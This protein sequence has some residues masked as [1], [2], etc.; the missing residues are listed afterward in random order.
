MSVYRD[1]STSHDI[2]TDAAFRAWAQ[3][4]HD[5]LAAVGLIQTADTGQIN[6]AT[7]LTPATSTF[8]GYEIWRFNDSDQ[9]NNPIYF[10]IEY[11][12]G[13]LAS[14]ENW[15]INVGTGS[16]GAG[17]LTNA[18]GA[19]AGNVAQ[20]VTGTPEYHCC[21]VDGTLIMASIP[22]P[23]T[24]FAGGF[25][26][27]IERLRDE[28]GAVITS[29]ANRGFVYMG[30]SNNNNINQRKGAVNTANVGALTMGN[31]SG[32]LPDGR[33]RACLLALGTENNPCLGLVYL[34]SGEV[35]AGDSGTLQVYG[36][37]RTYKVLTAA[38]N[39]LT[40]GTSQAPYGPVTANAVLAVLNE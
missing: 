33:K 25:F 28:N 22:Q 6:L 40:F 8:A 9:A 35:A 27:Q 38:L 11:G 18:G 23:G 17:T 30:G 24:S 12:K 15:R 20:T 32:A 39:S 16:D 26:I 36:T 37:N 1:I 34:K 3:M 13:G 2:T 7:V 21:H 29:G 5:S 4:I 31:V 14:R 10:K 19:I